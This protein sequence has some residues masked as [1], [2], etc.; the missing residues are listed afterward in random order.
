MIKDIASW[1]AATPSL[2]TSDD[3]RFKKPQFNFD[4]ETEFGIYKG[5]RRLGFIY[6]HVCSKLFEAS[7]S[8][9]IVADEIQLNDNGRTLGAIDFIIR[10]RPL[11]RLEHWEVAVKFYLLKDGLWY[12][13]N[14]QDR[15]DKKLL[16]MLDHQ[17]LMSQSRLFKTQYPQFKNPTPKLLLQGRL[18]V[19]PFDQEVIPKVCEGYKIDET[20]ISGFWCYSSQLERVQHPIYVLDKQQWISGKIVTKIKFRQ[21]TGR[22]EH[23]I[24]DKGCYW[25]IVNDNWPETNG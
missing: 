24:D 2:I 17:L 21:L 15:L 14:A 10:N 23:C 9:H 11:E 12:G 16:H 22:F 20:Q 1:I 13:P 5:N 8:Y 6:Q 4:K 19:N 25:F 18:Y 7:E 3:A